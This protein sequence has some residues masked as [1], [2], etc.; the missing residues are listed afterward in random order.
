MPGRDQRDNPG[1]EKLPGSFPVTAG[2]TQFDRAREAV[3]AV[4]RHYGRV[5]GL[6]NNAS[7]SYAASVEEID[8][9]LFDGIFHR[10]VPGPMA[11]MQAVI[12][13]MR[14][15]GGGSIVN[16]N[17]GTVAARIVQPCPTSSGL[18]RSTRGRSGFCVLSESLL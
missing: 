2:M 18:Q 9:A 7:R 11:A 1:R 8:P 16:I 14:A 4:H 15:Q 5:G 12:P 10:N 6:V 17:S 13:L 3:G